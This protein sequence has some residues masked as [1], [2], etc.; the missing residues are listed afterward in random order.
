MKRVEVEWE[1]VCTHAGWHE[2][3]SDFA[4]TYI[5]QV[6]YLKK[7]TRKYLELVSSYTPH[8]EVG[9]V[10]KIPLGLVRKIKRI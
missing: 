6:G 8:N 4:P 3:D 7:R 10:T 1:D 9:D 5:R 2:M